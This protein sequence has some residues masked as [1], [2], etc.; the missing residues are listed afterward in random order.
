MVGRLN[1][2]LVGWAN[3]FGLG[4]VTE[5]TRGELPRN[6][7]A[8]SMAVPEAQSQGS[9]I[10]TISGPLLYLKLGLYRSAAPAGDSECDRVRI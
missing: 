7:S 10:F 6:E 4:T 9:R 5:R 8:T 3:Y 2:K 1:R